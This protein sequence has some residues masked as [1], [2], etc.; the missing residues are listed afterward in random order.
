MVRILRNNFFITWRKY[1]ERR[2]TL[3]TTNTFN[4]D[5]VIPDDVR[6]Y[7]VM[8]V[9]KI[10]K[11]NKGYVYTL[12]HSGSLPATKIGTTKIR[13]DALA[14]FLRKAEGYDY[15]DPYNITKAS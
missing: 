1:E 10:L 11:T 2:N 8:E 15:T 3:M 7:S 4:N 6:L 5:Y 12:I 9:A 13:H 14:E